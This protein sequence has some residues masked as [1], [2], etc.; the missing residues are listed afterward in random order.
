M[1][2]MDNKNGQLLKK[3]IYIL[4]VVAGLMT[5]TILLD[6]FSGS[7][8]SRCLFSVFGLIAVFV[9]IYLYFIMKDESKKRARDNGIFDKLFSASEKLLLESQHLT[10][11]LLLLRNKGTSD[12]N[13]EALKLE[14]NLCLLLDKNY[15]PVNGDKNEVLLCK[16]DNVVKQIKNIGDLSFITKETIK[17]KDDKDDNLPLQAYFFSLIA[18]N[19]FESVIFDMN[20][21]SEPLSVGV[22]EV[23]KRLSEYL[24]HITKWKDEFTKEGSE[25]NFNSIIA[26]YDTQNIE[27]N[28]V[29]DKVEQEYALLSGNL[30]YLDH[31]IGNINVISS[32]I[33][34]ISEKIKVLSINASIESAK[35]GIYGKSFKVVSDEVK[36]L[37]GA[38]HDSVKQIVPIAKEI[39]HLLV[40]TVHKFDESRSKII[41]MMRK[42]NENYNSFY[43]L[44][45][46]YYHQITAMF[47]KTSSM[48]A[49]VERYIDKLVPVFN[50]SN[51]SIQ[52]LENILKM[53]K[54][55][56]KDFEEPFKRKGKELYAEENR[57]FFNKILTEITAMTTTEEELKIIKRIADIFHLDIPQIKK[58]ES[59]DI[60]LF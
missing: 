10:D 21:V 4:P 19:Y 48:I 54:E 28:E 25:K 22:F 27:F 23:K 13:M 55:L 12:N 24:E 36:K 40:E 26:T 44:L 35:A 60:E 47:S 58:M 42:Q 17:Q 20:E 43:S 32:M 46:S 57:A 16:I 18:K 6:F 50:K 49:E 5:F 30:Q 11:A 9:L 53:T 34:D 31:N 8:A 3:F 59:K 38:T 33:T 14:S 39:T 7:L 51:L 29:I 52:I 1:S 2:N 37:S 56:M 41:Q 15:K 45:D